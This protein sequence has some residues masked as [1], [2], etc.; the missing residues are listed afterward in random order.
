MTPMIGSIGLGEIG[1]GMAA[2][3]AASGMR[4]LG[5]DIAAPAR[6]AAAEAGVALADSAAAIFEGADI[7]LISLPS[8]GAIRE[9]Y[10]A[11]DACDGRAGALIAECST[12]P[13]AVAQ[14]FSSTA[15]AAGRAFVEMT[16]IGTGREARDGTLF[17]MTGGDDA[18]TD[19][20]A[21]ILSVAGRG[22]VH[23]GPVGAASTAK[24]LNNAIG[25]A[26]MLAFAEAIAEA[27][28][29]GIDAAAFVRAVMDGNGAGASVVFTR[30][31]AKALGPEPQPPTPLSLKDG[32][33]LGELI[34]P[35]AEAYPMLG[36]TLDRVVALIGDGQA[37]LVW[38]AAEAARKAARKADR[39]LPDPGPDS[40]S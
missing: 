1:G 21:P 40:G 6:A 5:F 13:V 11:L 19:R 26:T 18:M 31:A 25:L 4:V 3:L 14:E 20:L 35:V 34:G 2:T 22:H 33:A 37:G 29:S 38:A 12:I 30:H 17:F 9:T 7:T 36:L 23:M 27:E 39:P 15:Q 28:R 8:L 10:A 24:L 16:V 32:R